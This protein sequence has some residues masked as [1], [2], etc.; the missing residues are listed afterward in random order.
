MCVWGNSSNQTSALNISQTD[1]IRR[2]R[3][4]LAYVE[5][6]NC[7]RVMQKEEV[8][9]KEVIFQTIESQLVVYCLLR[10]NPN[11]N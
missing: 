6:D 9:E 11:Q 2:L 4:K 10:Q 5:M 7:V 1:A 3:T 8:G